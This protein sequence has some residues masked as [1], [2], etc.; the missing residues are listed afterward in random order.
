[1]FIFDISNILNLVL[2]L[3]GTILLVFLA[4]ELKKS[5]ITGINIISF[6]CWTNSNIT[7]R[8]SR[9]ITNIG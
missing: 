4:Q 2:M 5:Y 7:T 8:I 1:M 6:S 9:I 3:I